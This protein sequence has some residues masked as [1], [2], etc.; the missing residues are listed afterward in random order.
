MDGLPNISTD[1]KPD[2]S[3]NQTIQTAKTHWEAIDD[4][5]QKKRDKRDTIAKQI[6]MIAMTVLFIGQ[7]IIMVSFVSLIA[8]YWVPLL[9][10]GAAGVAMMVAAG[11]LFG[12]YKVY[13]WTWPVRNTTPFI[14]KSTAAVDGELN[15]EYFKRANFCVKFEDFN[16]H[17][18]K[19]I[20]NAIETLLPESVDKIIFTKSN[21]N[22]QKLPDSVQATLK[23]NGF[24]VYYEQLPSRRGVNEI[25]LIYRKPSS[26]TST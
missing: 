4:E 12:G 14:V 25:E 16:L 13:N 2:Q 18:E 26:K 19:D 1:I 7:S 20:S 3:V 9:A 15:K 8:T 5:R 17:Q 6:E 23:K 21:T 11:I 22:L 10:V 24:T